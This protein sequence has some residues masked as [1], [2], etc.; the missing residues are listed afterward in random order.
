[1]NSTRP[2]EK[3]VQQEL[4]AVGSADY[5]VVLKRLQIF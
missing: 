5:V 2:M 3:V 4:S 1:M